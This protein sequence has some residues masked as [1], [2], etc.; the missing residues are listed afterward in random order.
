MR[1]RWRVEVLR[2]QTIY[3]FAHLFNIVDLI[4]SR[5]VEWH[6]T[7]SKAPA[8]IAIRVKRFY[9]VYLGATLTLAAAGLALR[10]AEDG[11]AT[12]AG[13]LIFFLMNLYIAGPLVVSGITEQIHARRV[14]RIARASAEKTVVVAA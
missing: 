2:I 7:G 6:P 11:V 5:V 10:I 3:G 1:G 9:T 8:P 12:F 4:Q 14:A 13:M